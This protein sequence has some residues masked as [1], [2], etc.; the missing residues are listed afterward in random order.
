MKLEISIKPQ[1]KKS[2]WCWIARIYG[3]ANM[4]ISENYTPKK[5]WISVED[6]VEVHIFKG[7]NKMINILRKRYHYPPILI[8]GKTKVRAHKNP[9]QTITLRE[10][11]GLSRFTRDFSSPQIPQSQLVT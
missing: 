2:E 4:A 8:L 11:I 1:T 3:P 7:H 10:W 5:L 6:V 9:H